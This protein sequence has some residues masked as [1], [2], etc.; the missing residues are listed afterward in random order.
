MLQTG[1]LTGL[2]GINQPLFFKVEVFE[3]MTFFEPEQKISGFLKIIQPS[4]SYNGFVAASKTR[5]TF[6]KVCL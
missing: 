4:D 3:E 5:T 2:E 1:F 6:S